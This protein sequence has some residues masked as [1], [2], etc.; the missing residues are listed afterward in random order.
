MHHSTHKRIPKRLTAD[1]KED[2]SEPITI[3]TTFPSIPDSLQA[4]DDTYNRFLLGER[5]AHGRRTKVRL[6]FS[7]YGRQRNG[8]MGFIRMRSQHML[9]SAPSGSQ[10]NAAIE[11]IRNVCKQ[12]DGKFLAEPE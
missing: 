6:D 5:E 7:I 4:A 8:K 10:A 9:V 1:E 11:L 12:L 3:L 2:N